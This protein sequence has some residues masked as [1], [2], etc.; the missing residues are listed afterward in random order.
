[1][2]MNDSYII[3]GRQLGELKSV[4]LMNKILL[5]DATFISLLVSERVS[6]SRCI[7][8]YLIEFHIPLSHSLSPT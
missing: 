1:M 7:L 5:P 6:V 3:Y 2:E 4:K 8:N